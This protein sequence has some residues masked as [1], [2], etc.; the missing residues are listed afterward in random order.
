MKKKQSTG[1][2]PRS[3]L[4]P[5]HEP[6]P[7]EGAEVSAHC[8]HECVC[9][10]YLAEIWGNGNFKRG[11]SCDPTI[12]Y[13]KKICPY[14]TRSHPLFDAKELQYLFVL[15][16]RDIRDYPQGW[17][18]LPHVEPYQQASVL[19]KITNLRRPLGMV[20]APDAPSGASVGA[21][22]EDCRKKKE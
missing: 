11:Q 17:C 5:A 14:D 19:T 8:D 4:M 10:Q 6:L 16:Q 18:T 15:V 20:G 2:T 22:S 12:I 9:E 21:V 7:T 1:P 13:I 3:G